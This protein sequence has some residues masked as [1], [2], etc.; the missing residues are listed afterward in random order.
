MNKISEFFKRN[1]DPI[2][3]AIIGG[4][5]AVAVFGLIAVGSVEKIIKENDLGKYFYANKK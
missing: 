5:T 1:K 3:N 2:K 4:V